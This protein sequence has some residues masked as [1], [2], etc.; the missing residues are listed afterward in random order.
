MLFQLLFK[1]LI[2]DCLFVTGYINIHPNLSLFT[3]RC[4][5]PK[6]CTHMVCLCTILVLQ[7]ILLICWPTGKHMYHN[8]TCEDLSIT[9]QLIF[10]IGD[11]VLCLK[12]SVVRL[13]DVKHCKV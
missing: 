6:T 10:L 3:S 5:H 1:S 8:V 13:L 9:G 12:N 2:A 4:L 11:L 7:I